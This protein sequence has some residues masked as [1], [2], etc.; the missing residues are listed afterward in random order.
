M[1]FL[2]LFCLL[3]RRSV[4]TVLDFDQMYIAFVW[5]YL[6]FIA[7]GY[8]LVAPFVRLLQATIL[9]LGRPSWIFFGLYNQEML[10]FLT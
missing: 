2:H 4:Y 6:D 7:R 5:L 9:S 3:G 1:L 10:L 8:G